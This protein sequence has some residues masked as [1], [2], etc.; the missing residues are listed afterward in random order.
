MFY[1]RIALGVS[2]IGATGGSIGGTVAAA[3]GLSH[4]PA[5]LAGVAAVSTSV[6]VAY[7]MF[8]R[9]FIAWGHRQDRALA[10]IERTLRRHSR[11]LAQVR[12]KLGLDVDLDD[13]D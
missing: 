4:L 10:D 3:L 6:P 5:I 9:P 7:M 2:A 1:G 12:G 13:N 11:S 8:V